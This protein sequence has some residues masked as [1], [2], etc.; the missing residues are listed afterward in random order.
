MHTKLYNFS[1]VLDGG[2]NDNNG[3]DEDDILQILILTTGGLS[4]SLFDTAAGFTGQLEAASGNH[5]TSQGPNSL[6]SQSRD[7]IFHHTSTI[8]SAIA[9]ASASAP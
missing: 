1:I 5:H 9:C 3:M 8:P 4:L 6:R 7:P 2:G